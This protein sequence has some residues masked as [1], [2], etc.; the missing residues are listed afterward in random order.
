V[1]TELKGDPDA[2]R[3]LAAAMRPYLGESGNDQRGEPMLTTLE[4]AARLQVNPGTLARW[5]SEGRIWAEK[6][7]C[8]WRFRMDRTEVEPRKTRASHTGTTRLRR[9]PVPPSVNVIRG[10]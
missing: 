7:G 9:S 5:A 10:R 3:Q 6:V 4:M 2:L 8:E 1:I